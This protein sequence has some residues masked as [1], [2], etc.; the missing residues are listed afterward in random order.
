[1]KTAQKPKKKKALSIFRAN[2][3]GEWRLDLPLPT[4]IEGRLPQGGGFSETTTLENI[5]A[6]GAYFC[7]DSGISVG[8]KLNLRISLPEKLSGGKKITLNIG[9]ITVRLEE[10]DKK[11]KRQGVAIRFD[12]NFRF[13]EGR[14]VKRP[15]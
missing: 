11:G 12:R 15:K 4:M 14:R 8:S 7:L 1:M 9:G 13:I 3:R 10:P 2:R 5:S 6:T